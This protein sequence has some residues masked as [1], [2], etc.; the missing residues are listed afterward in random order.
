MIHL[1]ILVCLA[2]ALLDV[3]RL[4]PRCRVVFLFAI[5]L[6]LRLAVALRHWTFPDASAG[7][8]TTTPNAY[9]LHV[10]LYLGTRWRA[11]GLKI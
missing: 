3:E 11:A 2:L 10:R 1:L 4:S 7:G 6:E 5:R 9:G 8:S